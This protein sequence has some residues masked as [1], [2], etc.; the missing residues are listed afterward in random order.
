MSSYFVKYKNLAIYINKSSKLIDSYTY[1]VIL[2]EGDMDYE[3]KRF[4][5]P[6]ANAIKMDLSEQLY[7]KNLKKTLPVKVKNGICNLIEVKAL[8]RDDKIDILLSDK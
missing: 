3:L 8:L 1:K 2:I 5:Y 6:Y 4:R 7:G